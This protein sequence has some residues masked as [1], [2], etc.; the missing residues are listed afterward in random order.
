MKAILRVR[1]KDVG[2]EAGEVEDD[3]QLDPQL[4]VVRQT[5]T[6]A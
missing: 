4:M 5:Q 1:Q 2:D 6:L 3:E